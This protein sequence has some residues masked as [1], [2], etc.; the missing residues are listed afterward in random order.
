MI[1]CNPRVIYEA[2]PATPAYRKKSHPVAAQTGNLQ[3]CQGL[4]TDTPFYVT[5][6][7]RLPP[8]VQHL[9]QTLGRWD[10]EID[11]RCSVATR[12]RHR[13]RPSNGCRAATWMQLKHCPAPYHGLHRFLAAGWQTL[14][15]FARPS[16]S[17]S[18]QGTL[19][20]CA[21]V[22]LAALQAVQES[23]LVGT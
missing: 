9:G 6:S 4:V 3:A 5:E 14:L 16:L 11:W 23:L 1:D 8:L 10:C 21:A 7:T 15:S 13:R 2:V 19:F 20:H 22:R 17:L 12:S 18:R